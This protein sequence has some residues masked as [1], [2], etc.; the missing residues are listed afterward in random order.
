MSVQTALTLR[1]GHV[2]E[3]IVAIGCVSSAEIAC[4]QFVEKYGL[5]VHKWPILIYIA[6][7]ISMYFAGLVTARF[8]R[9]SLARRALAKASLAEKAEAFLPASPAV[10]PAKGKAV[11]P[12]D[13]Y[14]AA[15]LGAA[16]IVALAV[17]VGRRASGGSLLP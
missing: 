16:M 2:G 5:D 13:K 12:E 4:H 14:V 10:P 7:A 15:A 11:K 3:H 6:L 17:V 8:I 9:H 1:A